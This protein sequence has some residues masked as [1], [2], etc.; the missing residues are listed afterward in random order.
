MTLAVAGDE[1]H[2][3]WIQ[4]ILDIASRRSVSPDRTW[5]KRDI[6]SIMF[7]CFQCIK[8]ENI[9][10]KAKNGLGEILWLSVDDLQ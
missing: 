5:L 6:Q 3:L 1:K 10:K 4:K 2:R 8:C 9:S 7:S